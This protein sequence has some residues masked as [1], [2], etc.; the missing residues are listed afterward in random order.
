MK[1]GAVI[2][3]E[4]IFNFE[5]RLQLNCQSLDTVNKQVWSKALETTREGCGVKALLDRAFCN[6][7][8]RTAQSYLPHIIYIYIYIYIV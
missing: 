6:E 8:D 1:F 2:Y 3:G 5:S 4:Y 7:L